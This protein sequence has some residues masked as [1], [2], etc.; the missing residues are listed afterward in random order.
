MSNEIHDVIE[1]EIVVEAVLEI[2]ARDRAAVDEV[3]IEV[4]RHRDDEVSWQIEHDGTWIE[5]DA[6]EEEVVDLSGD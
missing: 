3:L 2:H 6:S 1:A 4:L 5:L